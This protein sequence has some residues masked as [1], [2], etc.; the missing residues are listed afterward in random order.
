M[1]RRDAIVIGGAMAVAVAIPPL[2]RRLPSDFE[3]EPLPGFDGFRRVTSG[4]VTGG[5]DP[6]FGLDD[7]LPTPAD[8]EP[9][10][11]RDPCLA[12]FGPEGWSDD[13]VPIALFTDINCT[14]CKGLERELRTLAA[15]GAPIR[16]IWHEMPLLGEGSMRAARAILAARFQGHEEAARQYLNTHSFPPGPTGFQR[17]AAALDV[18]AKLLER[19]ASSRR[20][21]ATLAG[22]LNLGMRLGLPGTPGTVIGRTLVIGAIKPADLRALIEMERREPRS[23]CL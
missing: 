6:F 22:S 18:D 16:L 19:E 14:L 5:I 17:M 1:R 20:V 23:I 10:P 15:S 9:P 21:L 11:P 4:A 3:F 13:R 8:P 12:L 2:L 7:R